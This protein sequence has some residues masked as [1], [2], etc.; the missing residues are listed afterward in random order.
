MF[1]MFSPGGMYVLTGV[2]G[3]LVFFHFILF[4]QVFHFID[5]S[6][7][8]IQTIAETRNSRWVWMGFGEGGKRRS[9]HP[10][11]FLLRSEDHLAREDLPEE[12]ELL[13]FHD[14]RLLR[15]FFVFFFPF[16]FFFFFFA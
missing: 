15:S 9:G 3:T 11:L 10:F 4:P 16:P 2:G 14:I 8:G 12:K 1:D 13:E 6:S 5:R 7:C